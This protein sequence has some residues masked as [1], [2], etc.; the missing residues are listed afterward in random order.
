MPR[1]GD[2][3]RESLPGVTAPGVGGIVLASEF[4][5]T[6]PGVCEPTV[7]SL[8]VASSELG[9][10]SE[11]GRRPGPRSLG[12][13]GIRRLRP[14]TRPM[15]SEPTV[16]SV[17][18]VFPADELCAHSERVSK[19]D[20]P[21]EVASIFSLPLPCATGGRGGLGVIVPDCVP[22]LI[23]TARSHDAGFSGTVVACDD[24]SATASAQSCAKGEISFCSVLLR[25]RFARTSSMLLGIGAKRIER[26]RPL[27]GRFGNDVGGL[28]PST[29]PCRRHST[30][31]G[32]LRGLDMLPHFN[33][34]LRP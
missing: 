33:R 24:D 19:F 3:G 23:S 17:E 6:R 2:T 18:A 34:H 21:A 13:V 22:R 15:V 16:E 27:R 20:G 31:V 12:I 11:L 10:S 4:G 9:L 1:R 28:R 14:R 8:G 29:L 5:G 7:L 26:Q 25:S 32:G 30:S